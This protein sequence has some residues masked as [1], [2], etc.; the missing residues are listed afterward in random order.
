MNATEFKNEHGQ[1]SRARTKPGRRAFIWAFA[2]GPATYYGVPMRKSICHIIFSLLICLMAGMAMTSRADEVVLQ[3]GD[4]LNG[5][6]LSM[7]TN[8]LVLQDD[9]LGTVTLSRA[10]ITSVIFGKVKPSVPWVPAPANNVVVMHPYNAP[11]T[12]SVSVLAAEFRGI[13]AQTNLIQEVQA[14]IL[15][16]SASPAAVNKFNEL[17]DGLSTGKIDM[18]E[19]RAEAQSAAEQLQSFTNEMGPDASGEAEGYLAIL[20]SF[21]RETANGSTNLTQ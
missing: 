19:L 17:L 20:N 8:S 13:R 16:S 9:N 5:Q 18:N 14:Q 12:N 4:M 21:L 15:G 6:V 11:E 2:D 10:K 1:Q 7:N 3:N